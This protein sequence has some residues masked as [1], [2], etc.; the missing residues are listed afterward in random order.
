MMVR[1]TCVIN[2]RTN[3]QWKC[4]SDAPGLSGEGSRLA[5]S[6]EQQPTSRETGF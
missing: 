6:N 2:G 5:A 4:L 3:E 1:R